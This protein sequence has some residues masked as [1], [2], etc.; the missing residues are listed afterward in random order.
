MSLVKGQR[1]DASQEMITIGTSNL[2][3]SFVSSH[4]ITGSFPRT[5]VNAA[6]GV[7]TTFGG[8]YTGTS[9]IRS[10]DKLRYNLISFL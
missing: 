3:G 2:L 10:C 1:I 7:R 6:S 4:T 8:L 5:V 9:Q